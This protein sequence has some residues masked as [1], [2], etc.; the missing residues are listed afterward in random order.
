MSKNSKEQDVVYTEEQ[1]SEIK[2]FA[3]SPQQTVYDPA[4][5]NT[6][7]SR[8]YTL[9]DKDTIFGYLKNPT[10]SSS[11]K[12]L[13]NA[14]KYMY[15]ANGHYRRLI[16]YYAGL[17]LWQYILT[18][19][20]FEK[21]KVKKDTFA[22]QYYKTAQYV[23]GMNIPQEMKKATTIALREGVF[24]GVI[25]KGK[26][27]FFLQGIEPS[28]CEISSI[29]DGCFQFKVDM[30]QIKEANLDQ[31]P[32]EFA[33]MY[34]EYANGGQKYQ[35]VP[36]EISF[37]VKADISTVDSV[38]PPFAS[39]FPA[40]YTIAAIEDIQE[41]SEE[42]KNYKMV[43]GKND[44]DSQT[45]KPTV[46]YPMMTKYYQHIANALGEY[47]GLAI[48]PFDLNTIDFEKNSTLSDADSV[49]KAVDNFFSTAGTSSALFNAKTNT[50]GALKL[51]VKSDETFVW[52]IVMQCQRLIN[53]YLKT[54]S[55]TVK[56]QLRFLPTT[57]YNQED[58]IKLYKEGSTYGLAKSF[59]AAALGINQ[60]DIIGLDYVEDEI[61]NIDNI[62]NPLKSTHTMS[63][64]ERGR[65]EKSDTDLTESGEQTKEDGENDNR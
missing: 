56:F 29:S 38:T 4:R 47:V 31:Y 19:L 6:K 15:I 20:N 65:P 64:D 2:F 36:E 53:R 50:A 13:I 8:T 42:L 3:M 12:G 22:K 62:L 48:T 18:P 41:V 52:T 10:S 54:M 61:I 34:S 37:C 63:S 1:M 49:S 40:L 7:T 39:T 25:W 59:Y 44:I 23:D 9:Q 16:D 17:P 60:V 51:A 5:S 45:K 43:W 30:S 11:A 21:D 27:S 57:I 24:Y 26:N 46:N 14:S 33:K 35:E 58:M 28:W 55:G 32:E